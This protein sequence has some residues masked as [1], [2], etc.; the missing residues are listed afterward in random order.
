MKNR[1]MWVATLLCM[2]AVP[3]FGQNLLENGSFALPGNPANQACPP[4]GL[5]GQPSGWTVDKG[6]LDRNGTVHIMSCPR[7]DDDTD[8]TYA[9]W[10][11]GAANK[12]LR[13]FQ[14]YTFPAG[15]E[16][17]G[18]D[19][20]KFSGWYGGG[21]GNLPITVKFGIVAG[22]SI[23][24]N[25]G[26]NEKVVTRY[27]TDT[28]AWTNVS[29]TWVPPAGTTQLTVYSWAI[30][31]GWGFNAVWYDSFVLE[32][33]ELCP[34][35]PVINSISPTRG[36][37]GTTVTIDIYGSNFA[38][39]PTARLT[40]PQT[41][42]ATSTSVV[43]ST[44][45]QAVFDLPAGASN[46]KYNLVYDQSPCDPVTVAGAYSVYLE[47][48]QNGSFETPAAASACAPEALGSSFWQL[49]LVGTSGWPHGLVKNGW[50]DEGVLPFVPTCPL[51]DSNHFGTLSS[52]RNGGQ[53]IIYYQMIAAEPYKQ[54]VFSGQFAA[55][56]DINSAIQIYEGTLEDTLI[57]NKRV[58]NG[59]SQQFDWRT[60]FVTGTTGFGADVITVA[61]SADVG[62]MAGKKAVHADLLKVEICDNPITV[63]SITPKVAGSGEILHVTNLAGTGFAGTP[64]IELHGPRNTIIATGVTVV[65]P[66]QITFDADLTGAA[67]GEY[68]VLVIQGSCMAVCE[69]LLM[70]APST[71]VNG[72][73]ED[74]AAPQNCGPP[75]TV[76]LGVPTGWS[77]NAP[78]EFVRDGNVHYPAACPCPYSAGG[79]YGTMSTG[80]GNELR[81]WQTLKV[82]TGRTYRFAGWF[83]GG[84]TN[85]VTIKLVDGSDPTATPL[86]S[87][88]VSSPGEASTTWKYSSVQANAASDILT[89]VWE[90]TGAADASA[91]HADGFTFE[92]PCNDPF[93][94]VDGDGDVDQTDFAVFQLCYT[95]SGQGPVPTTPHYCKCLDVDGAGGQP[96]DDID[97]GDFNKFEACASG[98][99]ILASTACDD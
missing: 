44:Q 23:S 75:P 91:T 34:D 20:Y 46:G 1:L 43:S 98:P 53:A 48:L 38:N 76:V 70:V 41:I 33:E 78:T 77:T 28:T 61:W 67:T 9:Y 86:A 37:R 19:S 96:D 24:G 68:E 3:A 99:G 80:F 52:T 7:G 45:A 14:T 85:T 72:E 54:Y 59:P 18:I 94:D 64:T 36:Q 29:F 63:T 25:D 51:G 90:L 97:Q 27:I 88:T 40:G 26:V 81:A 74:P 42:N 31:G 13:F 49:Q 83:A 55:S 56:G 87:T 10:S 65:S 30:N 11:D 84:G 32:K 35:Q 92:T 79:H 17:N 15:E 58:A 8:K 89:V 50:V 60:D 16:P 69:E 12:E 95:G 2:T 73:F 39:T 71:L 66:T 4:G 62:S 5:H 6:Y 47:S 57:G 82:M 22:T 93:A 21:K